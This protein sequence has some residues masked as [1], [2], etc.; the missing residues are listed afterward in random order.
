MLI[1]HPPDPL[2]LPRALRVPEGSLSGLVGAPFAVVGAGIE[3]RR[4]MGEA[5]AGMALDGAGPEA[6]CGAPL[7]AL[8]QSVERRLRIRAELTQDADGEAAPGQRDGT[9]VVGHVQS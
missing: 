6:Q 1:S 5:E 9:T 2:I 8:L 3:H 4:G 7:L